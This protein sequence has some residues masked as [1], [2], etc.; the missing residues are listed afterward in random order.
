MKKNTATQV[1]DEIENDI[2]TGALSP[3]DRLDEMSLANRF[4]VSRTPIR[5]ALAQLNSVGLIRAPSQP[6][7]H[8]PPGWA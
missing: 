1:R 6:R 5:E 8:R 3:G 2:L 7:R 4:G